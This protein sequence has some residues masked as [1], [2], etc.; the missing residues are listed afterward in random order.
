[1]STAELKIL[2]IDTATEACSVALNLHGAVTQRF[3]I[4]PN[5][6]SQLVLDMA[7]SL[8]K[9][10][11][12]DLEQLDALAVD[13]GPGSFTGLRIGVGVAQGLAYGAGRKV[14]PVGSLDALAHGVF[15]EASHEVSHEVPHATVLAAIDARMGQIYYGLYG[16]PEKKPRT[17][18][19][20]ALA[21]P[22]SLAVGDAVGDEKTIVGAGS[23]WDCYAPVMLEA[24]GGSVA[25]WLAGHHP[26]AATV[27]R[28]AAAAGLKSAISPLALSAVY[29]RDNVA[30][31]P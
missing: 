23:G 27:S 29:V 7:E 5:G 13:V 18:I 17:L 1:M 22:E 26:E 10:C 16:N 12:L 25:K 8:L 3:E 21:S 15:Y 31:R 24:L 28:M 30:A 4:A 19:G 20:P 14:I 11:G 9:Q 6:H 2:A